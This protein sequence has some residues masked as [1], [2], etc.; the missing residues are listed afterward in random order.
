[1]SYQL[2]FFDNEEHGSRR[3][4]IVEIKGHI[5]RKPHALQCGAV[6]RTESKLTCIIQ[7]SY[8]NVSLDYFYK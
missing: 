6:T 7:A 1:M 2:F 3:H 4:I 8:L 5:D